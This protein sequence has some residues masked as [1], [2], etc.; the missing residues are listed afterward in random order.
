MLV[1][2]ESVGALLHGW[3]CVSQHMISRMMCSA[4]SNGIELMRVD[5]QP[6]SLP[7]RGCACTAVRS[8][9]WTRPC[10]G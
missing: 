10:R 9:V 2:L 6:I 7:T 8:P 1:C 4:V 3:V 5:A